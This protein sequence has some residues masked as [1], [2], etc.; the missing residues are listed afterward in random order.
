MYSESWNVNT[1]TKYSH[2][3]QFQ[4]VMDNTNNKQERVKGQAG[5]Q[6]IFDN[7]SLAY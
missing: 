4:Q 5:D 2:K 1:F 3:P 7:R 6:S